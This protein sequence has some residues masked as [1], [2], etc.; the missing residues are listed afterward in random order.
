MESDLVTR[1]P[2]DGIIRIGVDVVIHL[3][4]LSPPYQREMPPTVP[5]AQ[6][7]RE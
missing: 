5:L 4:M 2:N 3:D 6:I 7:G 1:Q